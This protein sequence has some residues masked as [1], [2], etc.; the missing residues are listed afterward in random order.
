MVKNFLMAR[1][2][3]AASGLI[4]AHGLLEQIPVGS[5]AIGYLADLLSVLMGHLLSMLSPEAKGLLP[6]ANLG[7]LIWN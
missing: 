1:V 4:S 3:V 6:M 5:N 2:A 7:G